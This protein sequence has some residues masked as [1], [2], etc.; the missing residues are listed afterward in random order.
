MSPR[1]RAEA[2]AVTAALA[3][4]WTVFASLV[5]LYGES[6]LLVA[7]LLVE[8]TWG[9]AY[10]VGQV[11]FKA[12]PLLCTGVAVELGLRAG[13]FNIGGEGQVAVASLAVAVVG[14]HAGSRSPFLVLP[15][16]VLVGA[17]AGGRGPQYR[18]CFGRASAPTRSSGPS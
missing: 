11:L 18:R 5:W 15:L 1:A 4:A 13:L 3:M 16:L 6:P 10:G 17:V 9:T 12:T 7:R 2:L 8:G 14:A